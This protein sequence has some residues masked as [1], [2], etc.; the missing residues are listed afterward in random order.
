MPRSR[1]DIVKKRTYEHTDITDFL[2]DETVTSTNKKRE[3]SVHSLPPLPFYYGTRTEKYQDG[4]EI[5]FDQFI[6][7]FF[8]NGLAHRMIATPEFLQEDQW[9]TRSELYIAPRYQMEAM[10]EVKRVVKEMNKYYKSLSSEYYFLTVLNQAES[11][12]A[13]LLRER[14]D[15]RSQ[16]DE[17]MG[18]DDWRNVPLLH[19]AV[20][21]NWKNFQEITKYLEQIK[22][23]IISLCYYPLFL[24]ILH[25]SYKVANEWSSF[26]QTVV[27]SDVC[28]MIYK[29]AS[30]NVPGKLENRLVLNFAFHPLVRQISNL[31]VSQMKYADNQNETYPKHFWPCVTLNYMQVDFFSVY[32][33][34]LVRDVEKKTTFSPWCVRQCFGF[35]NPLTFMI[36][37][38]LVG[39]Q[40]SFRLRR[41][42]GILTPIISR[43]Y[44]SMQQHTNTSL[45]DYSSPKEVAKLVR[46]YCDI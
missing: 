11:E 9:S 24:A 31:R 37:S 44:S 2:A 29:F 40:E 32:M 8:K 17:I 28:A 6:Y 1:S 34:G 20:S 4:T 26:R 30:P 18:R 46:K 21:N 13:K 7:N 5:K 25:I 27:L 12:F 39:E 42:D 19:S 41:R 33:F 43:N 23:W 45:F 22:F 10:Q 35:D 14:N 3:N 36:F 38:Y 16:N 15:L